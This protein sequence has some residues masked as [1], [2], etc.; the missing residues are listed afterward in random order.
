MFAEIAKQ[1][2]ISQDHVVDAFTILRET[3]GQ[4]WSEVYQPDYG[5]LK[6]K[7]FGQVAQEAFMKMSFS[8][9]YIQKKDKIM[10]GQDDEDFYNAIEMGLMQK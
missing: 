7:G 10:L 6:E 3:P 1:A 4:D 5:H 2:G 8:Q 9:E